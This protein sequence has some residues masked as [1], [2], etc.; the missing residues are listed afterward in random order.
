MQAAVVQLNSDKIALVLCIFFDYIMSSNPSSSESPY[1]PLEK[2]K[3]E[4]R[5]PDYLLDKA[6]PADKYMLEQMS[7]MSQFIEWSADAHIN[8]NQQVRKTNG[9][10]IQAEG[11]LEH[12]KQGKKFFFQGW[13][14]IVATCGVLSGFL[15]LI[16]HALKYIVPL[17]SH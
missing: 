5:I 6:S 1:P 2:P 10:L 7:I 16:I 3:F 13:K 12:I 9:R 8:T 14:M 4:S 15:A 11:T 17:L